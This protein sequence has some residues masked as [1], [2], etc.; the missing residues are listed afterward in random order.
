M[1]SR[2]LFGFLGLDGP[3]INI[4]QKQK[5][6]GY[7]HTQGSWMLDF[8]KDYQQPVP[9]WLRRITAK[10][11][12][13]GPRPWMKRFLDEAVI[14]P[15]A[16]L[17][18]SPIRQMKGVAH[19]FLFIDF[20]VGVE[21]IKQTI[22]AEGLSDHE[23]LAMAEFDPSPCMELG[24]VQAPQITGDYQGQSYGILAVFNRH[25]G[26]GRFAFMA[27]GAEAIY[28][29][30]ALYP[31]TPPR[32]IVLQEHAFDA[33]PWGEWTGPLNAY[34]H[35]HWDSPPEWLVLGIDRGQFSHHRGRYEPL[36]EDW[37]IESAHGDRRVI[38]K[39]QREQAGQ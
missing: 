1:G 10:D 30:S 11:V 35:E 36:G 8:L 33:N 2:P 9:S 6:T 17:D 32:G 27:F 23:L 3:E 12:Q 13:C 16:G 34:A 31:T 15:G 38:H 20:S 19:A 18:M 29:L 22:L 25:E 26:W 24:N 14:Y 5:Q 28:A 7:H 4:G 39:F 21:Q 37:A